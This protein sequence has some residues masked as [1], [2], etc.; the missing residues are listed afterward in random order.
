MVEAVTCGAGGTRTLV[1]SGIRQV[2]YM[3]SL[4]LVFVRKLPADRPLPA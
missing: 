4:R 1:R 3:L 2:F